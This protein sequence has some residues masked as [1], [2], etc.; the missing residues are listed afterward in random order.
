MLNILCSVK[1]ERGL[2]MSSSILIPL[3]SY[4]KGAFK[5][6]L[7]AGLT[8]GVISLPLAMAF[9][10]ASG[11]NP[12]HGIYTTIIAA[13]LVALFGGSTYQVAGP[14]GAFVPILLS[15]VLMYGYENLLIAGFLS[16]IILILM[17]LLDMGS[18]IKFIPRSVTIGFTAGIA[19]NIFSGQI[20]N[21]L[22]LT[23]LER[24][25]S[26]IATMQDVIVHLHTIN[27]YSA[28]TATICLVVILI[29]PRFLPKVPGSLAGLLVSTA[30]ATFFFP[31][32]IS[33]IASTFGGIP[34]DIPTLKIPDFTLEKLHQ[35]LQPALTIA[36][37]GAI[38][39]LMSAV[40]ADGMTGTQHNSNKELIGQG[41]AN[42]VTPLFG[43]IPATG[44]IARTATNIKSG[45]ATR[46]SI[47]ISALFVLATM[48]LLAPYAGLIPLAS[49]APVLMIVSYNMSEHRAFLGILK[50]RSLSAGVLIITFFLTLLANLTVA[51]EVGLLLAMMLFVKRMSE[52]M[53]VTQV[54]PDQ[55]NNLVDITEQ[56]ALAAHDCPQISI[57]SIEGPLFFGAAQMFS[58]S[59]M[60]TINYDPK[61][62]IL[63]MS[64]VPLIDITGENHLRT[65]V[66]NLQQ[67]GLLVL[68][69]GLSGQP[70]KKLKTTGLYDKIGEDHIF[71]HTSNAITYSLEHI[72]QDCCQLCKKNIFKACQ[73]EKDKLTMDK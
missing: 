54:V 47:V 61:I 58:Q 59:I 65:I 56:A 28:L 37:L 34:S 6:D 67:K 9:A 64:K 23:G 26:F 12:E 24:H 45:A 21:F 36:I 32:E 42:M 3:Q 4:F 48:L 70:E 16:G 10:I 25:E 50:V 57:F 19:V 31:H 71:P 49:M 60:N 53:V 39:S 41:I 5:K 14:T 27:Y 51:V 38:E 46:Y 62:I 55:E 2:Y 1:F 20:S 35:L 13:C 15:I 30:V 11:A 17:G 69:C 52:I 22:G 29:T 8:V 44:A 7:L 63:R 72:N 73:L 33:T 66:E 43:G 18:L 40:V 68:M